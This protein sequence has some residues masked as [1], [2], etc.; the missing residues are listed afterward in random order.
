MS[1]NNLFVPAK[2]KGAQLPLLFLNFLVHKIFLGKLFMHTQSIHYT[3]TI[4]GFN[5]IMYNRKNKKIATSFAV[6]GGCYFAIQNG[7]KL[8][9]GDDTIWAFNVSIQT[10]NHG[11]KDRDE[12]KV[13]DIVIGKNCWL[14]QAAII[15]SGVELGDNVI[16][17]AGSV[18]TKSFPANVVIAGVPAKIIKYL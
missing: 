17:G 16:I 18:V 7:S 5:N 12:M 9:I 2:Y 4:S 1:I 15:L 6:S 11:L 10:G 3:S 13:K 8:Y 14:G